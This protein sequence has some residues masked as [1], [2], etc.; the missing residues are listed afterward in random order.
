M[1]EFVNV[2]RENLP[3]IA[4]MATNVVMYFFVFLYKAKTNKTGS[5][6]IS[7]MHNLRKDVAAGREE[8]SAEIVAMKLRL[9]RCE[10]A[11]KIILDEGERIDAEQTDS[12]CV[13][14]RD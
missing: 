7:S 1:E 6:L 2:L 8:D 3:E 9:H 13:D 12:I 4:T 11:L 14:G 5:T 10:S